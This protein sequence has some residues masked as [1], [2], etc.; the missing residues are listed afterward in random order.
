MEGRVP[1]QAASGDSGLVL[2]PH[3]ALRAFTSPRL[4]WTI[5]AG[6]FTDQHW[7]AQG[8][9]RFEWARFSPLGALFL[10]GLGGVR[11]ANDQ[12]E[13]KGAESGL[14]FYFPIMNSSN[15]PSI[16]VELSGVARVE[17][18]LVED[19]SVPSPTWGGRLG[20]R[21]W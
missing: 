21:W 20:L 6:L 19:L 18:G 13:A 4:G 7:E 17:Q 12:A 15:E 11:F 3:V 9:L 5:R 10:D 14:G 8:G 1:T 16:I 2:T